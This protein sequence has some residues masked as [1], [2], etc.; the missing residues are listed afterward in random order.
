[1]TLK[2]IDFF[3]SPVMRELARQA[4]KKGTIEPDMQEIIKNASFKKDSYAPTGDVFRDMVLLAT[5]LRDKGYVE[6]AESLENKILVYKKAADEYNSELSAA[7]PEGD[8]EICD[9]SNGL[10]DVETLESQHQ[11]MV[12]VVNK[13]PNGKLAAVFSSVEKALDLTKKAQTPQNR[14]PKAAPVPAAGGGLENDSAEEVFSG[15]SA[16]RQNTVKEINALVKAEFGKISSIL[17]GNDTDPNKWGFGAQQLYDYPSTRKAYAIYAKVDPTIIESFFTRHEQLYGSNF[18]G[19][20][21]G[22][23]AATLYSYV[24]A[25]DANSMIGYAN[26]AGA[27]IG[28][29]YFKGSQPNDGKREYVSEHPEAA[30]NLMFKDSGTSIWEWDWLSRSFVID[31]SRLMVAAQ[32]MQAAHS[33]EHENLFGAARIKVATSSLVKEVQEILT[34]YQGVT[35]FFS[36]ALQLP[37]DAKSNA[38][39][40]MEIHSQSEVLTKNYGPNSESIAKLTELGSAFWTGWKPNLGAKAEEANKEIG[41]L[42]SALNA[43]PLSSGDPIVQD[44]S[45]VINVLTTAGKMHWAASKKAPANSQAQKNFA[46]NQNVTYNLIKRIEAG[47]GKPY[48][49]LY[50]Q[51]KSAFPK[52]TSYEKLVEEAQVWLAE[53]SQQTGVPIESTASATSNLEKIADEQ[54]IRSPQKGA[55]QNAPT[56]NAAPGTASVPHTQITGEEK[57]AVQ[58]MQFSLMR[59]GQYVQQNPGIFPNAG[60]GA[61]PILIQTGKGDRKIDM[62]GAWGTN[63]S[64]ALRKAQELLT[65]WNTTHKDK[66]VSGT[67]QTTQMMFKGPAAVAAANANT[68]TLN[69]L[70]MAAYGHDLGSA[71]GQVVAYGAV[72]GKTVTSADLSSLQALYKFFVKSG[73]LA[74]RSVVNEQGGEPVSGVLFVGFVTGL[75]SMLETAKNAY[76][77]VKNQLNA[78]F[79]Q[80]AVNRWKDLISV[81]DRFGLTAQDP[82]GIISYNMLPGGGSAGGGT[83]GQT[84]GASGRGAGYRGE[85]DE[86]QEYGSPNSRAGNTLPINPTT[87]DINLATPWYGQLRQQFGI[88]WGVLNYDT[89]SSETAPQLARILFPSA[90]DMLPKYFQFITAL[91]NAIDNAIGIWIN[92]YKPNEAAQ[93]SMMEWEQAWFQFLDN[94]ENQL[95]VKTPRR[96]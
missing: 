46:H 15:Q 3:D 63:T 55:P 83:S 4:L 2:H 88:K 95:G 42:V 61:V 93:R 80:D 24:S 68:G 43:K 52:A 21:A 1:M 76:L 96:L 33:A 30:Q 9:A 13:K 6:E 47:V 62:D 20:P 29:K 44:A 89:F 35:S 39:L 72:N 18:A 26:L 60:K 81:A 40:T 25:R 11:K 37:P 66:A 90:P 73:W 5:G 28:D 69:G 10:G 65:E 92:R 14:D 94:H 38:S 74:E 58:G 79:Y 12:E 77:K 64:T 57:D 17:R 82:E 56:Q 54:L 22:K 84:G 50:E 87:G 8:V 32:E 71:G 78:R 67:L 86:G 49:A 85:V 34:P 45:Q 59:L 75:Q 16:V 36:Q 31:K 27:G 51:I 91:R 53:S 7:H 19:D 23:I 41:I 48:A 70:I